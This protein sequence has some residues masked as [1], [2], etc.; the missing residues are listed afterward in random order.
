MSNRDFLQNGQQST[1]KQK[2]SNADSSSER[3]EEARMSELIA[4]RQQEQEGEKIA[5]IVVEGNVTIP[6]AAICRN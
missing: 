5:A 4:K 2:K 3:S 1:P 6:T